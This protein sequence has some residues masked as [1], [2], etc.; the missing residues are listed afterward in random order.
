[1]DRR[2]FCAAYL[3]LLFTKSAPCESL[4]CDW[5]NADLHQPIT[6]KGPFWVLLAQIPAFDRKKTIKHLLLFKTDRMISFAPSTSQSISSAES[7][8]RDMTQESENSPSSQNSSETTTENKTNLIVNYLPQSMNQEEIRALFNTIGKV[9]SCKLIRDKSTGQSLGYGFVNYANASDAEKAIKHFNGMRLKNKKIKV[10][11]ARPSSESIKGANL[12]I[13]GLP[14]N[15]T[16][17]ELEKIFSRCGK[18]ITSRLLVDATTGASKGVGFIRFDQR[19]E[20][21]VAIQE[22]NG[23]RIP[24]STE[25]ITVKFASCPSSTR[26][27]ASLLPQVSPLTQIDVASLAAA[28]AA[29]ASFLGVPST[30]QVAGMSNPQFPDLSNQQL[31]AALTTATNLRR[32][33]QEQQMAWLQSAAGLGYPS[34]TNQAANVLSPQ[35]LSWKNSGF[36]GGPMQSAAVSSLKMRYN[37]L[38]DLGS[39]NGIKP[40]A[41]SPLPQIP[42]SSQQQQQQQQSTTAALQFLDQARLNALLASAAVSGTSLSPNSLGSSLPAVAGMS[43][44]LPQQTRS[45]SDM[46]STTLFAQPNDAALKQL[47]NLPFPSDVTHLNP[48]GL[49][50]LGVSP[51]MLSSFS[52]GNAASPFFQIQRDY[53]D[54]TNDHP[55]LTTS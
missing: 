28:A 47:M 13:C 48:L 8:Q 52:S 14:K 43:S 40:L 34:N 16:Q 20:A 11:L 55:S 45:S 44:V 46:L 53:L 50:T 23:Y 15:I 9:S 36:A 51:E 29:T 1:M 24:G 33:Q 38:G 25:P 7:G 42:D 26:L 12:Y 39:K 5:L 10:S 35:R 3:H 17:D 37:P 18:I 6:K 49:P 32:Q 54:V 2:V 4:G 41:A 22:L 27:L 19:S 31:M 30:P 21:E